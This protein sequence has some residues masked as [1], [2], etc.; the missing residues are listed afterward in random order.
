MN[1][2]LKIQPKDLSDYLAVMSKAVF[3]AGVSWALID[4]RWLEF[5]NAFENFKPANVSKFDEAKIAKIIENPKLFKSERKV[6]ATIHN[7]ATMVALDTEY[8]GFRNYLL[9]FI[10]YAE[11]SKDLRKRFKNFGELSVYY[12]LF[13]LGEAVPEFNSWVTTIEG[14]HP[15]MREMVELGQGLPVSGKPGDALNSVRK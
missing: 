10:S 3:Q 9:S 14:H 1:I 5:E 4:S 8:D 13:R 11:L 12:F 15:R 2:P 7:A 6:R